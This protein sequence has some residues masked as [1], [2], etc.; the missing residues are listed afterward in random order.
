MSRQLAVLEPDINMQQVYQELLSD[1]FSISFFETFASFAAQIVDKDLFH[2]VLT[3]VHLTDGSLNQVSEMVQRT[4]KMLPVLVVS[5]EDSTDLIKTVCTR[6]AAE[7]LSKPFSN[8]LL[9]AKC[10]LMAGSSAL[11]DCDMLSMTISATEGKSDTLTARE[12]RLFAWLKDQDNYQGSVQN[13]LS[14]LWEVKVTGQ[15]LHVLLSRVRPKISALNLKVEVT[16][17][18]MVMVG[19]SVVE[20][21]SS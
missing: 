9:I 18:G 16:R 4:L 13:A 21:Q 7:Y 10:E 8:S 20:M 12:I 6:Y 5:H 3:E 17:A 14:V 11:Y 15:S 2:G 19:P 1:L